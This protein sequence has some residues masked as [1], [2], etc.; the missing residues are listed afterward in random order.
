MNPHDMWAADAASR[1]LGMELVEVGEGSAVVRMTVRDDMVN[2]H[3]DH[4]TPRGHLDQ[5]HAERP[6]RGVAR[7]HRLDVHASKSTVTGSASG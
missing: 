2:G 4:R 3:P 6:T 5:L 1:A 7:P